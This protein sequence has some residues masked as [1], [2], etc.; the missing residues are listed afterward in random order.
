[1]SEWWTYRPEDLLLFAPR[2]YWS[3]FEL[4]NEVLWPLPLVNLLIG[5]GILALLFRPRP[6]TGRAIAAVLA[7]A[8]AW[9]GWSFMADRYAT[10]NWAAAYL[11]PAF[12][13]Q[14]VF[15]AWL[16]TLRGHL[17]FAASGAPARL[18]LALLL[19]A[20]VLHP[21][22]AVLAGRPLAG[23]EIVGIAPDPTVIATLGLLAMLPRE[24]FGASL[25][26]IP[27]GWCLASW[28]TLA[29]MGAWQAWIPLA[30]AGVALGARLWTALRPPPARARRGG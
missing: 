13:A 23:A 26:L 10:I 11:A 4:A 9:V 22:G 3:L 8:W 7:A 28:A 12:Y 19:Y 25:M 30:A 2:A 17:R 1:M 16:G 14:A 18:G 27:L 20:V 24:R 15:L 5:A 29:T 21:L 6:W